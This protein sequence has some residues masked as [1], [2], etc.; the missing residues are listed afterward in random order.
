MPC[1]FRVDILLNAKRCIRV[2]VPTGSQDYCQESTSCMSA[3]TICL[4]RYQSIEIFPVDTAYTL[5]VF[6][7]SLLTVIWKRYKWRWQIWLKILRINDNDVA[8]D[9]KLI[10]F[11]R[12]FHLS[13]VCILFQMKTE[14]ITTEPNSQIVGYENM[15]LTITSM[16]SVW[17]RILQLEIQW[18]V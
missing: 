11:Q 4:A 13:Y 15:S 7:Y 12:I 6:Y 17:Q 14:C 8:R 18:S 16:N 2:E 1:R 3:E 9:T 10:L 5:H